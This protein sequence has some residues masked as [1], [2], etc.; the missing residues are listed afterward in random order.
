M[1]LPDSHGVPRV[2]QY[3]GSYPGAL[4]FSPTSLLLSVEGLS[5]PLRLK[6]GF[7]TPWGI[8]RYPPISP[9]TPAAQRQQAFTRRRFG[10]F[11][12]RSPL[13]GESSFLSFPQG[14]KMFQFPWLSLLPY[15]FR[16]QWPDI[17]PARLPHSGIPGSMPVCGSPRLFAAY[18][19]LLRLLAPR[20]PPYALPSLTYFFKSFGFR[21]NFAV[22]LSK[23][24]LA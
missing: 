4:V 22:Q 6:Q 15:G 20:H 17:T 9:A 21:Q 3:L 12:F 13:L 18:R 1:V 5:R 8:C 24:G 19:A 16:Q 2:P 14:T 11:P 23:I 7:L 10:L